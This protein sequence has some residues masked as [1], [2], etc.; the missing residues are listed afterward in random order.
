MLGKARRPS[1][2][3]SSAADRVLEVTASM[4]GTLSFKD[5]VNLRISGKFEGVLDTLGSLTIGEKA[6]VDAQIT[7][8]SIVVAGK[9]QGKIVAR[10]I[11]HLVPPAHVSGEIWTPRLVIDDGAVFDGTCH[12]GD[13]PASGNTRW[14]SEEEVSQ[15]L[16]VEQKV[17][18]QWATQGR[19]PAVREGDGWRFEKAR[20][21]QWIATERSR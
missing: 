18:R 9:A 20:L 2:P 8:E 10:Q 21:D 14:L 7:G 11:L 16:E 6:E 15:Y 17:I 13:V 4:Q 19:I 5:P 3:I 1:E 12:M